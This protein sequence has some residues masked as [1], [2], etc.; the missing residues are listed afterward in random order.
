MDV[1]LV[2]RA[3]MRRV[4]CQA[5]DAARQPLAKCLLGTSA[6]LPGGSKVI[7]CPAPVQRG[8]FDATDL[9]Q[10]HQQELIAAVRV[11]DQH[12]AVINGRAHLQAIAAWRLCALAITFD[13]APQ[14][15]R[16]G[17]WWRRGH[18]GT[19]GQQQQGQQQKSHGNNSQDQARRQ[20]RAPF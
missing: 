13:Q 14:R 18:A 11:L 5:G 7:G 8:T 15:I 1:Q 17:R 3:T 9:V 19:T 2:L 20:R 16:M 10:R 6:G 4:Q 12:I